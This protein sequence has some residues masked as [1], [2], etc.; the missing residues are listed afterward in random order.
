MFLVKAFRL[1]NKDNN[2]KMRGWVSMFKH[3][4]VAFD[5]SEP[6]KDGLAMGLSFCKD[7]ENT[8]LSVVYVYSDNNEINAIPNTT[9][10]SA[11]EGDLYVDTSQGQAVIAENTHLP[12]HNNPNKVHSTLEEVEQYVKSLVD[13]KDI[14]SH[15]I[16][17]KGS[18]DDAILQYA[19]KEGVD[20]IIVG[21]SS[22]SGLKKFFLGSISEKIVKNS[23]CPVL[24]AK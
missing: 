4:L 19:E 22:S 8:L 7:R 17:L 12:N 16:V 6:S 20:L 21:N 3:V 1:K 24:I 5:G 23:S 14:N 13:N 18:T 11:S 15:F 9:L 2:L 10:S